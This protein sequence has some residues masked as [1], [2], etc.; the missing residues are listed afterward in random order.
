[1]KELVCGICGE[2]IT[3]PDNN[4]PYCGAEPNHY[5]EADT[6]DRELLRKIYLE[7]GAEY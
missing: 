3:D 5:V 2:I 1:M 4:C 6:V 7:G